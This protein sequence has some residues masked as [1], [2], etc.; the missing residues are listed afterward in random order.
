MR[1]RGALNNDGKNPGSLHPG[2]AGAGAANQ[3]VILPY[4]SGEIS[5]GKLQKALQDTRSTAPFDKFLPEQELPL[6]SL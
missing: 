1:I 2:N 3:P 6:T 5:R 4:N